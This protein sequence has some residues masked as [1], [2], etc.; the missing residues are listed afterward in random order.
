MH[1]SNKL[2]VNVRNDGKIGS[3]ARTIQ[4]IQNPYHFSNSCTP[5]STNK[6]TNDPV[7]CSANQ[8][9]NVDVLCC[10]VVVGNCW[11]NSTRLESFP[12]QTLC[13]TV[14]MASTSWLEYSQSRNSIQNDMQYKR[15]IYH[16]YHCHHNL[17]SHQHLA[18]VKL[19]ISLIFRVY[20][21]DESVCTLYTNILLA[22]AFEA[23]CSS[24]QIMR[25]N[26]D[27]ARRCASTV[28]AMRSNSAIG[29][30]ME[31]NCVVDLF[32]CVPIN[33]H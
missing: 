4:V 28:L 7:L 9:L 8:S 12:C 32:K 31:W 29:N 25:Q 1:K 24:N 21:S 22:L 13:F 19:F 23:T 17:P 3:I 10:T 33:F 14:W 26:L 27:F 2:F 16:H 18:R 30:K 5:H 20:D 15:T 6:Q 11:T